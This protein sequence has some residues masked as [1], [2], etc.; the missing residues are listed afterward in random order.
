[1][2]SL[3]LSPGLC[4]HKIFCALQESVS[5][6]VLS[7]FARSPAWEMCCGLLQLCKNFFG[8]TVLQFVGHMLSSS[9]V[10]LMGTSSKMTYATNCTSEVCCNWSPY[11]HSRSLLARVSAED[12]K[13]LKGR[14]G[15]VS[16]GGYCSFP[17]ILVHT[18]FCLCPLS[19]SSWS[20]V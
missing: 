15:T 17:W 12:T 18:K 4:A 19:I 6:E 16:C 5:L 20:E 14:S 11:P 2:G 13:T 1:M 9:T 8:I 7:P 10:A 3:F